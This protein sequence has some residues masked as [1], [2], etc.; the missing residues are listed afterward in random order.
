MKILINDKMQF[1][2]DV[3]D[4][5]K[6]PALSDV[7]T[8]DDEFT[9]TF[10]DAEKVNCIGIGYTDATEIVITD[11]V[12]PQTVSLTAE[13]KYKNGLYILDEEL[14]DTEYT[15]SHDGTYIGRVAIGE[16]RELHGNPSMETGFYTNSENRESESGQVIPGS[17]GYY[18]RVLGFEVRYEID[19]TIYNDIETAYESQI[20]RGFPFFMYTIDEQ[21]KI[22][23]NMLRFYAQTDKSL[24]MLQ[25]SVYQFL[26][27]YKFKFM[28]KF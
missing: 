7:Y 18:G 25:S 26:Y 20:M 6:S 12:S 22:P 23:V 17:G 2:T 5:I 19:D 15:I 21:H 3:P 4:E 24:S 1:A 10:D 11:G 8:D 28:E 27:S 13:G 14:E 9:I 16:Y